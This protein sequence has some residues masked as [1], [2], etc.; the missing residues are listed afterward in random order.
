M[1]LCGGLLSGY[2]GKASKHHFFVAVDYCRTFDW[3][4]VIS[5]GYFLIA[6][7]YC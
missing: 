6:N 2:Q 1:F 7:G 5:K 4:A 3:Q